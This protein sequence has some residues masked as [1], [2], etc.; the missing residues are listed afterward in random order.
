MKHVICILSFQRADILYRK[1]YKT[2]KNFGYNDDEIFVFVSDN[3]ETKED[4]KKKF[5]NV[6]VF[7][8]NYFETDERINKKENA[9]SH[10]RNFIYKYC[11]DNNIEEFIML[12]DDYTNFNY[13]CYKKKVK[14]LK[15]INEKIFEAFKLMPSAVKLLAL[16]QRGDFIYSQV[17]LVTNQ[18]SFRRKVMNY[19]FCLSSRS[20]EWMGVTNEDVCL[21]TYLASVG[22]LCFTVWAIHLDQAITQKNPGGLTGAYKEDGG[23]YLKSFFPILAHPTAVRIRSLGAKDF[24]LHHLILWRKLAPAIL[25]DNC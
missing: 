4:Y 14:S 21:Y 20:V 15:K 2:M 22:K 13:T 9:A 16:A 5:K 11:R 18:N 12:D 7:K 23:T 6:I 24:R 8:R 25:K 10:A 19:F 3:D 1:T 17:Y